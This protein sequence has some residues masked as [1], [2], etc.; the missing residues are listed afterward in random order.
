M[1]TIFFPESE[2]KKFFG[3]RGALRE[4]LIIFVVPTRRLYARLIAVRLYVFL[5]EIPLSA[6]VYR[7][8]K[9][10]NCLPNKWPSCKPVKGSPTR[11]CEAMSAAGLGSSD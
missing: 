2:F 5:H 4:R 1:T 11:R 9:I 8:I 10:Y 6:Y 7:S 3:S